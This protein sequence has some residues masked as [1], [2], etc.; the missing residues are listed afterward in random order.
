MNPLDRPVLIFDGD[1]GFCRRWIVRWQHFTGD[2]VE[3]EPLQTAAS[4]H[5]EIPREDFVSAV[6]LIEPDG[7][8]TSGAQAVFGALAHGGRRWP[9][10]LYQHLPF[11]KAVSEALYGV[12]ARHRDG[13]GRITNLLW[14]RHV[15][16]PGETRT[17][18][19][20]L[21]GMGVVF[22]IAF[23]SL[24]VQIIGL[25]GEHGILPAREFL[26]AVRTHVGPARYW[27]LPTVFWL[28][29][30]NVALHVVCATGLAC[31][32]LVVIGFV[33]AGGLL[34]A[35]ILYLSL[36]GIGQD[37][38]RFQWDTLLLEAGMVA[39]LLA[40]W[41]RR[42]RD[43]GPPPRA[44]VWLARWLIF[45]LMVTSAI[46]KLTS[47]DPTWRHLT[48]L[49]Y[50]YFT[51]PLP[52]WTA[53]YAQHWPE[54]FQMCSVLAMFA[55]EGLAPFLIWAPRRA[56][57]LA[58]SVI[59]G[60]Q[61]LLMATGNYGFFNVLTLVLCI[62]LLDDG[63]WLRRENEEEPIACGT[64]TTIPEPLRLGA[65]V[66][67]GTSAPRRAIV[68]VLFV[69]TLVPFA[70]ALRVNARHMG[71]VNAAYRLIAPFYVAN[72]YGLFA[73]MTTNR[74]EIVIEGSRDGMEWKAYEFCYKPGGLNRRPRMITPH[75]PRVDR[76]MW[77]AA[78][79]D[80]RQNRWFLVLCWRLL[81]GSSDVTSL[82]A[83]NPFP[84]A[85]PR[86]LRARV[87][88]YEFTTS[89]ERKETGAWWKRTLRGPY[90]R[91]LMLQNGELVPAPGEAV[92]DT[93]RH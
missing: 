49:D 93:T 72:H 74:P 6:H 82:L 51:Q 78:L 80:V 3:Y 56:R 57:F 65:R 38:L 39:V 76:Q 90:V 8:A 27:Y 20:F 26:D 30:S 29:V 54:W 64:A 48:A 91:D 2:R 89:N 67:G 25:V 87:Y 46:V 36:L 52:P 59:A 62:P 24:W 33:P 12:V 53:W 22:A 4:R 7:S 77:F 37:F 70:G 19:L 45:R 35:W 15:A 63:L 44:A 66:A 50:H 10:A 88:F 85:P 13:A 5:P 32:L 9:L 16:P 34:G 1:C 61:L 92:P 40:P 79:G 84:D 81:E 11:F 31:S 69:A 23:V 75:M 14:G 55:T 28:N 18:S 17:V 58:A 71:P 41:R 42:L 68:A 60:F 43:A 86:Y 83:Y 73:V 47:G 21:R